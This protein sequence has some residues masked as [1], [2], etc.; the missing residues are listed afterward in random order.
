MALLDRSLMDRSLG[1]SGVWQMALGKGQSASSDLVVRGEGGRVLTEVHGGALGAV[2]MD[3]LCWSLAQAVERR[4]GERARVKTSLGAITRAM[5]GR[6]TQG[7]S[8][9]HRIREALN[10]LWNVEITLTVVD[11]DGH[12]R[13]V[14]KR[15][16]LDEFE[17]GPEMYALEHGERMP[18]EL[19]GALGNDALEFNIANWLISRVEEDGLRVYLDWPIQ[20]RLGTGLGKRLWV[21]FESW[22]DYE[23]MKD[24]PGL[25]MALIE[26]N[27]DRYAEIGARAKA[28]TAKRR[29]VKTGLSRVLEVDDYYVAPGGETPGCEFVVGRMGKPDVLVVVRKR[30][31]PEVE[32]PDVIVADEAVPGVLIGQ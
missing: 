6:R 15:R 28:A 25:E 14:V 21:L 5:Y 24:D 2:E 19:V 20:R 29:A 3:V 1:I 10:N 7:G 17:Y 32:I 8:D 4:G 13:K 12:A 18:P 30:R 26:L 16:V 27:A 31:A 9:V 22:W 11:A 23:P